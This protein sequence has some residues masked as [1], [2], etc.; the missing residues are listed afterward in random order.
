M[1]PEY[2]FFDYEKVAKNVPKML[3]YLC[4]IWT[5]LGGLGIVFIKRNNK[6]VKKEKE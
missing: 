2:E 1:S 4:L 3:R 6:Y 5:L